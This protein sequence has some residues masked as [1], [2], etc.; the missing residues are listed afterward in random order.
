MLVKV[1]RQDKPNGATVLRTNGASY[2]CSSCPTFIM[3]FKYL[4]SVVDRLRLNRSV[5]SEP[6]VSGP[7]QDSGPRCVAVVGSKAKANVADV[8]R[9]N[10]SQGRAKPS[11]EQAQSRPREFLCTW[12]RACCMEGCTDGCRHRPLVSMI[13]VAIQ[14][15]SQ[16]QEWE[17]RSRFR[18]SLI[19]QSQGRAIIPPH[20]RQQ[21][22]LSEARRERRAFVTSS[23]HVSCFTKGGC[24]LHPAP[25]MWLAGISC[26]K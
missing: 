26:S 18:G 17:Q 6:L 10:A 7:K 25:T 12:C 22:H 2:C 5:N 24:A 23:G 9:N 1:R 19:T 20:S 15:G 21:N 11:C 4:N 16:V 13:D 14:N 8:R 3:N